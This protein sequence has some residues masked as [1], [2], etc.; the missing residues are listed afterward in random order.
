M[1]KKLKND[2]KRNLSK[3]QRRGMERTG[4][5]LQK[6][7]EEAEQAKGNNYRLRW[8]KGTAYEQN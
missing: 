5:H 4:V 6:P 8:N 3:T 2:Q 7:T 1:W